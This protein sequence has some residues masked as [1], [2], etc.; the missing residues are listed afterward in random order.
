MRKYAVLSV[1]VTLLFCAPAVFAQNKLAQKYRAQMLPMFLR[2]VQQESMSTN[3]GEWMTDGQEK[4]A[5]MLYQEIRA[6]GF[7]THFSKDKYIYVNIPSNFKQHQAP[8]LGI[9]AHYDTTPDTNGV[10]IKPQ[11]IEKYDG[12]PIVLKTGRVIDD[13]YLQKMIGKTVVTS[14]GTTIL[15]ADDKAGIT[16]VMTLIKTLAENPE[17]PHGPID[18]M[19]TPNE[20]IGRSAERINQEY[21]DWL[22]RKEQ[23]ES[24]DFSFN[25][26]EPRKYYDPDYAFDFDGAVDGQITIGNFS[27][28]KIIVSAPDLKEA[29]RV[30]LVAQGINGH[31]SYAATNGYKNAPKPLSDLINMASDSIQQFPSCQILS[32][33]EKPKTVYDS[34]A[35]THTHTFVIYCEQQTQA[36]EYLKSLQTSTDRIALNA[37]IKMSMK[38]EKATEALGDYS[39]AIA[40]VVAHAV[41]TEDLPD[42]SGVTGKETTEEEREKHYNKGYLEPHHMDTYMVDLRLRYFDQ[43]EG[44]NYQNRVK[45]VADSVSKAL[46]LVKPLEIAITKQYD[47]VAYGVK[48]EMK[49]IIAK[50]VKA[51]GVTPNFV[52]KRSGTTPAVMMAQLGF[53]GYAIFTGQNNPHG[54]N[55]WLSEEDMF[56][57]YEVALNLVKEVAQQN[58]K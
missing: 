35:N 39:L 30:T 38:A 13:P 22:A 16:I 48:P 24:Y 14:D 19:L 25:E 55:E 23:A 40:K 11:V 6:F 26:P 5:N 50:A 3:S 37:Q 21:K 29:Y 53:G 51:A 34:I 42:H 56:K 58:K 4:M 47:N 41:K 36:F 52:K 2:Y 46:Y 43:E 45:H 15:G 9:S 54:L 10:N 32:A 44:K 1:A 18:I 12:Q 57:A 17:I 20:E 31:Q 33:V 7:P 27:A 8:T 28:D 49:T